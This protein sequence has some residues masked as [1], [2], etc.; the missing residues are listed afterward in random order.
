M[1][2]SVLTV[3]PL[4]PL[5]G[6]G[7][8]QATTSATPVDC[9]TR[10]MGRTDLWFDPRREQYV[11]TLHFYNSVQL[12]V[13]IYITIWGRRAI[14]LLGYVYPEVLSVCSLTCLVAPGEW[15]YLCCAPLQMVSKREGTHCA[16]CQTSITTLWRRNASGEPVCNACGLYYKLH[17]V[18]KRHTLCYARRVCTGT[19]KW[20][21]LSPISSG[22]PPTHHEEGGHSD[23]EQEGVQ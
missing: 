19:D 1:T 23:Q 4:P 10:P 17:H 22:E 16:N 15:L 6:V 14:S 12:S 3:G 20:T 13:G 18:S 5:C 11:G 21:L 8:V 9:T 2:V 7:M